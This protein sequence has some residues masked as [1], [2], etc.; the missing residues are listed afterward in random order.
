MRVPPF[1]ARAEQTGADYLTEDGAHRLAAII[2]AAWK[3]AG[4]DV[5]CFVEAVRVPS[6]RSSSGE[7][8]CFTVRMPTLVAGLPR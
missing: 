8:I 2:R 5:P 3:R 7:A 4:H 1:V 6:R